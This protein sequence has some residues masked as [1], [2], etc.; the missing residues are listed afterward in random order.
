MRPPLLSGYEV[1]SFTMKISLPLK[2]LIHELRE[3]TPEEEE[4]YFNGAIHTARSAKNL[5]GFLN[6]HRPA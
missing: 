1:N 6:A 5:G 3:L 2:F 4:P